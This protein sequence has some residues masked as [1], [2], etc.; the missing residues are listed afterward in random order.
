MDKRK[1]NEEYLLG[2]LFTADICHM[3]ACEIL[4]L[5]FEGQLLCETALLFY[6]LEK[7]LH[8]KLPICLN[9]TL[10]KIRNHNILSIGNK[11]F[12]VKLCKNIYYKYHLISIYS[13]KMEFRLPTK[14]LCQF[15][16]LKVC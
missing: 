11:K 13:E 2:E 8:C 15:N 16:A 10:L 5:R 9:V 3:N 4:V 14:A 12:D 1:R 6:A 7:E